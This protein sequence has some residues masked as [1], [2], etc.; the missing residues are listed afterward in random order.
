VAVDIVPL[1]SSEDLSLGAEPILFVL[2]RF[3]TAAF[4]QLIGA[5]PYLGCFL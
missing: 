3:A 4:I 1:L 2:A 5:F